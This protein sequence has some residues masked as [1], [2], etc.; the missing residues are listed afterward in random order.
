MDRLL[1]GPDGHLA[2]HLYKTN[3]IRQ[4]YLYIHP[5]LT[6]FQNKWVRKALNTEQGAVHTVCH[7]IFCF[8]AS[9]VHK[10]C[11]SFELL[12]FLCSTRLIN[13]LSKHVGL[14]TVSYRPSASSSFVAI[15]NIDSFA[16]AARQYGLPELSMF[17]SS[18][19]YEGRKGQLINVIQS[20]NQLG[21]IVSSFS[22]V[23]E[24]VKFLNK[25]S[26][27]RKTNLSQTKPWKYTK[28]LGRSSAPFQLSTK[29]WESF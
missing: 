22:N 20:L 11:H 2:S 3:A 6:Y 21:K 29:P 9:H 25:N 7:T 24:N 19:L 17:L 28:G 1:E 10:Y 15:A 26:L 12:G 5:Q 8:W 18:D 13:R 14:P 4:N 16:I 23:L 27:E